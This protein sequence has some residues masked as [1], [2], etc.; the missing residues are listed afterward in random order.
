MYFLISLWSPPLELLFLSDISLNMHS[1]AISRCHGQAV[2]LTHAAAVFTA[3]AG[4]YRG[5]HF[6]KDLGPISAALFIFFPA[7]FVC[8]LKKIKCLQ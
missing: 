2:F 4:S 8:I 3:S 5:N 6:I 1:K 7:Y